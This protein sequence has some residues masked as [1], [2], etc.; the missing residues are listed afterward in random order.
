MLWANGYDGA[1]PYAYQHCFGSCWN[2]IDD[3]IY[4][5]HIFTYPTADGVIDTLAWEGFREATDDVRYLTTLENLLSNVSTNTTAAADQARSFLSTLKATVLSK[6]TDSG[7]YN[8]NM[9]IDLDAV[10]DQVVGHID[11]ITNKR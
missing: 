8:L 11:A 7:K 5:D 4:R 6:Q 9:D 2:D 10:R 3:P 1:M